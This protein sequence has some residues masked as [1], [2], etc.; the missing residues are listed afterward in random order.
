MKYIRSAGQPS[1]TNGRKV[2]CGTSDT[3]IV[4]RKRDGSLRTIY[5]S[6]S[7]A[8]VAILL[9]KSYGMDLFPYTCRI[10]NCI[11][12]RP[13]GTPAPGLYCKECKKFGYESEADAQFVANRRYKKDRVNLRAYQCT[14]SSEFHITKSGV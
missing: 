7:E 12:I 1:L 5:A 6:F 9:A 4:C 13:T 3:T 8:R 14:Y 2:M 10:C 11:H